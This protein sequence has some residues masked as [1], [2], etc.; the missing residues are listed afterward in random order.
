[1]KVAV[2]KPAKLKPPSHR[3]A[4]A[5]IKAG[6]PLVVGIDEVGRG[7]WAGPVVAAA[8]ILPPGTRKLAGV[9]DSK[10]LTHPRRVTLARLIKRHALAV[11]VGWVSAADIDAHGL[12]W[13]VRQSGLRALEHMRHPYDAVLLDGNHNYLRD[14]CY[15]Q[16]I[17]KGDQ[18]SLSIAAASV[19]AKVARDHYM[20]LQHRLFPDYDFAA[21]KGYGT[22]RHAIAVRTA[23]SPLH[24][25][26]FKPVQLAADGFFEALDFADEHD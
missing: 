6:Y 26:L 22:P 3:H 4:A 12:T 16:T 15:A 9:T 7:C 14:H 8:V 17:I 20:K 23:L 13:A 5:L 24:R 19:V 10:L 21:N 25:R 1:M 18:L 11:G 2:R